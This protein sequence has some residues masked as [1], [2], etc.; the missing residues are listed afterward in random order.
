MEN[1]PMKQ[2]IM[3]DISKRLALNRNKKDLK[4]IFLV[5]KA[6]LFESKKIMKSKEE[7]ENELEVIKAEI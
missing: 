5:N 1:G 7:L 2:D 6:K 4:T 3:G